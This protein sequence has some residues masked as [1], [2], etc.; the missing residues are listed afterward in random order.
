MAAVDDSSDSNTPKPPPEAA[1]EE[2]DKPPA[3]ESNPPAMP[4]QLPR[5][6]DPIFRAGLAVGSG[7]FVIGIIC[8]TFNLIAPTLSILIIC[9]GLG[10]I[11]GAFG[12]TAVINYKGFVI[13]GV[14]AVSIALLLVVDWVMRES[15][16]R[17]EIDGDVRGARLDLFGDTA[18][19]GADHGQRFEFYI[20]G[21]SVAGNRDRLTLVVTPPQTE[22]RSQPGRT[23]EFECIPAT[24]I[25]RFIGS[26][27]TLQW[28]FDADREVLIGVEGKTIRSGPCL[29]DEDDGPGFASLDLVGTAQAQDGD[30]GQLLAD[31]ESDSAAVRR[32]AREKL[33]AIGEAAVVPMMDYWASHEDSYPVRL[34]VSVAMTEFLRDHKGDRRE[35]ASLLTDSHLRLL[36]AA[37]GD[38]DRNLRIYA[39]EFLYDL[40][41]KRVVPIAVDLFPAASDDGRYNLLVVIRG[42]VPDLNAQEREALAVTLKS[43]QGMVG[44]NTQKLIATVMADLVA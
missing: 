32:A 4:E 41:D 34:G 29:D 36:A 15:L 10:I 3:A 39:S 8:Q 18:F 2:G 31:L 6:A 23:I 26:G 5:W 44:P 7:L 21:R 16:L 27:R 28:R 11:F 13:A 9:S 35:I 37:A 25:T 42:A 22:Q 24:A 38:P 17:L 12:S 40:G 33:A 30:I 14:A 19:P 20:I 1:P 43:W